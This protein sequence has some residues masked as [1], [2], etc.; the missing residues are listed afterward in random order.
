MLFLQ[1][2]LGGGLLGPEGFTTVL[3]G[4]RHHHCCKRQEITTTM[5]G[6]VVVVV[7]YFRFRSL[8]WNLVLGAVTLQGG[9]CSP[10][11]GEPLARLDGLRAGAAHPHL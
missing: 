3:M 9:G 11:D 6:K 7:G 8:R 5:G 4:L 10:G 2:I 1:S